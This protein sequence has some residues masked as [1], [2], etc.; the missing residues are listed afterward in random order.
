MNIAIKTTVV[1]ATALA[2]AA[3]GTA[4]AFAATAHSAQ[5]AHIG[6]VD[7]YQISESIE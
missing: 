4:A 7:G 2:F 5:T 1:T 3:L 6:S